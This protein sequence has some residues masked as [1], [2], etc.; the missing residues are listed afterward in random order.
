MF[1]RGLIVCSD[2]VSLI[3]SNVRK[4]AGAQLTAIFSSVTTSYVNKKR[5]NPSIALI[6][7]GFLRLISKVENL[8]RAGNHDSVILRI[9]LMSQQWASSLLP[10]AILCENLMTGGQN[11][12]S[13]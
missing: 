6:G 5:S 3:H 4:H 7:F 11:Q 1:Q 2:F 10:F 9:I 13:L 8:F 12:H